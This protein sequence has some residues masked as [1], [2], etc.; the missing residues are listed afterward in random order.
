[1][2]QMRA[3]CLLL[4]AG[5]LALFAPQLGEDILH[6]GCGDGVLTKQLM[7]SGANVTGLEPDP[8]LCSTAIRSGTTALQQGAHDPFG[9][10]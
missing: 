8:D 7:Q 1:M 9:A 10:N 3:S 4:G 2:P 5:V 6:L